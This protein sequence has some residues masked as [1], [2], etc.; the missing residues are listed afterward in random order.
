MTHWDIMLNRLHSVN[1]KHKIYL[2]KTDQETT[3]K[4]GTKTNIK[5]VSLGNKFPNIHFSKR[6]AQCMFYLIHGKTIKKTAE[7]LNL[8][9]R[10]VEF[11]L[12]NI[13]AK[14]G[15]KKKP[16]LIGMVIESDFLENFNKQ[17]IAV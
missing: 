2:K 16:Q 8:S 4:V 9:P 5:I 3:S 13:K 1:E 12:K 7:L 10:T 6:E 11:Y 17:N 14:T 15:C